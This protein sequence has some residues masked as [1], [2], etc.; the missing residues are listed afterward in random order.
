MNPTI[1]NSKTTDGTGSGNFISSITGLTPNTSYYIRAYAT[2]P[3]GTAYGSNYSLTTDPATT[4]DLDGNTY[5]LIRIGTQLWMKENLQTTKYNDGTSIPLVTD[6]TAWVNLTTPGYC[7][8]NND[9]GTYKT[10]YGALYNW[11]SVNTGKLCPSGWHV[12]SDSEWTA[13]T[14]YLIA[15]GNNYD[16]TTTGNKIAKALAATTNWNSSSNAGA[17][18]N[19]DYPTYRNKS[20]YTAFPAGYRDYSNGTFVSIGVSVN[21]W[22][23]TEMDAISSWGRYTVCTYTYLAITGYAKSSGYSVR[24]LKN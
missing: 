22:S 19:T 3:S 21:W 6:N 23:S 20:G 10:T 2:N 5:N 13:F 14:N 17:V 8:Y 4:T 1:T 18:G 11:Y 15:N 7:W 24:C 12:P 16:G 9:A